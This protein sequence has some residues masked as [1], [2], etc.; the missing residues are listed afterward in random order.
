MVLVMFKLKRYVWY[1]KFPC[2]RVVCGMR[3]TYVKEMCVVCVISML[4]RY[5]W[6]A[7]CPC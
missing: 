5:V 7:W 4:K 2:Y 6:Y 3:H 1:E